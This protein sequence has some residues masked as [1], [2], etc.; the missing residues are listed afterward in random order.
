MET[1][2]NRPVNILTTAFFIS[3]SGLSA[4]AQDRPDIVFVITDD[5]G[6]GDL[7]HT[8]NPVVRNP[9]IDALTAESS[10]LT[11]F[12]VAPTCSPTRAALITWHWTNRP[13]VRH[14][15]NGRSMRHEN[16]VTIA[17][18]LR[19]AGY[20]TGHFGKWHLGGNFP[21]RPEDRAFT[22]VYRHGGGV[23]QAPDLRDNAC[24]DGSYFH[25]GEVVGAKGFRT[26]VFFGQARRFIG[27]QA[28]KKRSFFARIAPN[29]PHGPYHAPKNGLDPYEGQDPVGA[30]F[31]ETITN[32]DENVG[33]TRGLLRELGIEE[34]TPFIFT[35][36]N[37]TSS[38]AKVFNGGMRGAKGN[39][40]GA[41][42][43]IFTKLP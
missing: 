36:G 10:N 22:G 27:E 3:L 21:H 35:T 19:D 5:R 17:Q 26:D 38:G 1:L 2:P 14:T 40:I 18:M 29:A 41:C 43:A 24:F 31:Y 23:G 20:A 13:G 7:G 30:A 42:Y 6:C 37:G 11:D 39:E 28:E 9:H 8:G 33:A 32:I 34:N 12:H 4:L 16:E 25:N 15:V